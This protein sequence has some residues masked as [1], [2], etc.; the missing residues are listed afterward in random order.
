MKRPDP[1][2]NSGP[3]AWGRLNKTWEKEAVPTGREPLW[4]T[5][6]GAARKL[7]VS[8]KLDANE[9]TLVFLFLAYNVPC[10]TADIAAYAA[11]LSRKGLQRRAAIRKALGAYWGRAFRVGED[12][13]ALRRIVKK[14]ERQ[15]KGNVAKK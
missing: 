8:E 7:A 13:K 11:Q 9:R 2:E 6:L 4:M 1:R 15:N 5:L 14:M 10:K 3:K 12:E